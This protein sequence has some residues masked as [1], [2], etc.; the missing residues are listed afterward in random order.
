MAAVGVLQDQPFYKGVIVNNGEEFESY[1]RTIST[2]D[3]VYISIGGRKWEDI[4]TQTED[5]FV[6]NKPTN[7]RYQIR[8]GF[9]KKKRGSLMFILIDEL[10]AFHSDK[11]EEINYIDS[12]FDKSYFSKE[13]THIHF[14]Y[15]NTTCFL[16]H[17]NGFSEWKECNQSVLSPII[18]YLSERNIPPE[19]CVIA[20]YVKF[21]SIHSPINKLVSEELPNIIFTILDHFSYGDRFYDWVGYGVGGYGVHYNIISRYTKQ[22]ADENISITDEKGWGDIWVDEKKMDQMTKGRVDLGR[23][24]KTNKRLRHK[25]KHRFYKKSHKK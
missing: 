23:K 12:L 6:D 13:V 3:Y 2:P 22:G 19:H 8:P 7:S 9:M 25:H 15:M 1:V 20:N 21:K 17:D 5:Q 11:L 24:R 18:S 4:I 14:I 16:S 10:G